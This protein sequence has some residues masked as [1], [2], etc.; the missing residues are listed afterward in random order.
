MMVIYFCNKGISK[1]KVV[2][3]LVVIYK[4]KKLRETIISYNYFNSLEYC[5]PLV[6][7]ASS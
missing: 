1:E 4:I 7:S 5:L 3:D 6:L 2:W